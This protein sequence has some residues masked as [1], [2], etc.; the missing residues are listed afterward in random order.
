MS[1]VNIFRP[2]HSIVSHLTWRILL[3]TIMSLILIL[4]VILSI[5]YL[6]GAFVFSSL[7]DTSISVT[8]EKINNIFCNVEIAVKNHVPEAKQNINDSTLHFHS[9]ESLLKLN[10]DIIGAAIAYNPVYEP[11]KGELY[12]PYAYRN[13]TGIHFKQLDLSNY[14]YPEK[15]WYKKPVELKKGFWSEPYIDAGGGDIPMITYSLPLLNNEGE[16]LAIYTADISLDWIEEVREKT[17][18]IFNTDYYLTLEDDSKGHAYSFIVTRQGSFVA[19]P[20]KNIAFRSSLKDYIKTIAPHA[21]RDL[22]EDILTIDNT[23]GEFT[24]FKDTN[25]RIYIVY[26]TP[27]ERTDWIMAV[28]LP[29]SD[30]VAPLNTVF[31]FFGII[32]IIGLA[33]IAMV[34]YFTVRNV[35]KPIRMFANSAD[36]IAKGNFQTELPKI[37]NKDEMFRLR[38][39]FELMK[40]S[41]IK[42]IE[43]TKAVNEE[44]GRMEGELQTARAIQMS[45]LPKEFPPFPD[46]DDLDVFAQLTPAKE[47]GG[48][49][50]DFYIRDEK[51]FFCIGDVSGKGVPAALV[52]AVT[53]GLFRSF[54]A[55]ES[56]PAKIVASINDAITQRNDTEMFV[57][58][59]LGVLDLPSGRLHYCNAAH[60]S[61][62]LLGTGMELLPI[63]PNVPLGVISKYKFQNQEAKIN[64]NT[65]IFAYTDGLT[66]A[67]DCTP[68]LFGEERMLQIADQLCNQ[69]TTTPKEIL[70]EMEK[71]VKEFVGDAEPSDD[72]TM[73]GIQYLH[74]QRAI[75]LERS[76]MLP[77]DI[78]TIP[79]LNAFIDQAAEEAQLPPDFTMSLNLAVEEAVVNVMYY[80]YPRGT[81]GDVN[82]DLSVT[83][84]QLI[85]AII[86]QGKP[87]DPTSQPEADTSLSTEERPIGGLGIF[88]LRQ[89][90]D[91]INYERIDG[92]NVLTLIKKLP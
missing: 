77:N 32:I 71:S 16:V 87:F 12:A 54:S 84:Q 47:V 13:S 51:L 18:S 27:L 20:D 4:G 41:L 52:M 75:K 78:E 86:D 23:D 44:K 6:V 36:E 88:L 31:T 45:M 60:C 83:D 53:R 58:F 76:L 89:L 55:R 24:F 50:Y 10:D 2:S 9:I 30:L 63:I 79:E 90:M 92:K 11:K 70:Y 28:V 40:Q 80:A 67:T 82:I 57:T 8:N 64:A 48:D 81:H 34:C 66:E 74:Q 61:P 39:S 56:N 49:L 72:L 59:F 42:Q 38:N 19:H 65:V 91:S 35:T 14:N 69:H 5:V 62:I 37:K 73:L 85:I 26:Y 29:F 33:I 43:E 46:R 21:K 15:A 3:A 22:A 17:D 68:A 7:Y 1:I 25:G